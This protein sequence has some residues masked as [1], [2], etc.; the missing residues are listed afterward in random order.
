MQSHSLHVPEMPELDART[1]EMLEQHL[2]RRAIYS[3]GRSQPLSERL[4]ILRGLEQYVFLW[5]VWVCDA[6]VCSTLLFALYIL[7]ACC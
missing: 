2:V 1:D 6:T 7:C 3:R 4:E 5:S